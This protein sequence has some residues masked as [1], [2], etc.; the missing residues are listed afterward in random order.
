MWP[1]ASR[2]RQSEASTACCSCARAKPAGIQATSQLRAN[3]VP[4]QPR[5]RCSMALPWRVNKRGINFHHSLQPRTI[6]PFPL[7]SPLRARFRRHYPAK[8]GLPLPSFSLMNQNGLS[9]GLCFSQ[10]ISPKVWL[11]H[12]NAG[13]SPLTRTRFNS[14]FI[15]PSLLLPRIQWCFQ[16]GQSAVHA[17]NPRIL[18]HVGFVA[19]SRSP[20]A[21]R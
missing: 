20:Q 7:L 6:R 10:Q 5:M 2:S 9:E 15:A 14:A 19:F 16:G 13:A 21:Q 12:H 18:A 8:I 11:C 17:E 4:S 3:A 1:S